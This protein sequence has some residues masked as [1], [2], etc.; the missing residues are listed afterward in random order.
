MPDN[1]LIKHLARR[2]VLVL[3][4]LCL[5][6][7]LPG[8]LALPPLD[9][10][11]SRF[12]Q[13][14]KQ[15]IETGDYVDIRFSTLPRYN[16]PVGI[17]WL[18]AAATRALGHPPYNRIWTYRLPSL[19]GGLLAVLLTFWCARAFA[20]PE[21]ALV[22][23]ALLG[24]TVLLTGEADIATTDA[25]LL[26]TIVG[27][28]A[29]LLRI[30][31]FA[32]GQLAKGPSLAMA[33][34]GWAAIGAGILLKG[35]VIPAVLALTALALSLWDRDWR[36]LRSIR[37]GSGVPV[38]L[39]IVLPWAIAIAFASHGAFYQ[40]SL[41]HD[42]AAKILGGQESHGAPP[43]YYLALASVTLWPAILFA[44]PAIRY[45][46]ANRTQPAIRFLLA[47]AASNWLMFELVPTKLPHYI[48]PVYPA[49]AMVAALWLM[50][51]RAS[52][53]PRLQTILRIVSAALFAIVAV[54]CVAAIFLV[55][56]RFG[57]S[58]PPWIACAA[59]IVGAALLAATVLQI[60]QSH[61]WAVVATTAGALALYPLLTA[62]VAP[63]LAPL[64]MSESIAAHLV[65]DRT[66]DDPPPVLAGYAEP[67]A[68]FLLGTET[69]LAT[70]AHAGQ[71]AALQGGLA[72]VEDHERK[73]FLGALYTAGG[74]ERTV[75]QLS[76]FDYSRGRSVHVTVYRVTPARTDTV[77]PPE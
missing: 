65:K 11:E 30:Y 48:L 23:A 59:V 34:A 46:V 15:M 56:P 9:R 43:G 1:R 17:Y 33:L 71:T 75:D 53:E 21:T 37:A 44:L 10:D 77:P 32:H 41:G 20:P 12:A 69:Q 3:V 51:P 2:P 18:Q 76:G 63:R 45:A 61:V 14:S 36:W 54:A 74:K 52:P 26:A 67:S 8:F 42:F 64:W 19:I 47:W 27:A 50:A 7:W 35:P 40:R 68:V 72:L 58:E 66:A 62:A 70:G 6:A 73:H 13:A 39:A 28:Q 57:A 5:M 22:A 16:K 4:L 49:L 25:A 31:L 24:S 38:M 29:V 55:P 60:R